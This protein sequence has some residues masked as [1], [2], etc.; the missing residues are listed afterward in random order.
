MAGVFP[1]TSEFIECIWDAVEATG[2]TDF[3][4]KLGLGPD[5]L[6]KIRRW[7]KGGRL[8]YEDVMLM[9][10]R[11]GLF[12]WGQDGQTQAAA[13]SLEVRLESLAKQLAANQRQGLKN[14]RE[15]LE[16]QQRILDELAVLRGM[17]EPPSEVGR[18]PPKRRQ[19]R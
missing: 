7:R 14:Q 6:Q 10:Q 13:R 2:P 8:D 1:P 11:A 4:R 9:L 3:A 18:T 12:A 16:Q 5:G 15:A 19:A 17:L